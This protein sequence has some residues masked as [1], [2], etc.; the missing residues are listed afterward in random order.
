MEARGDGSLVSVECKC[1]AIRRSL[2]ILKH[3]GMEKLVKK[4]TFASYETN[5]PWQETAKQLAEKFAHDPAGGWFLACG[6][7]GSGKTHLCVAICREMMLR[8]RET[9]YMLWRDSVA[10]LKGALNSDDYD[11]I[12]KPLKTVPVL[13]IDDFYKV[14]KGEQPTPADVNIAFEL[15]NNRYNDPQLVTVISTE[16]SM[17]EM[18]SIDEATASRIYERSKGHVLS[19]MGSDKNYRLHGGGQHGQ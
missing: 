19:L 2:T 1:M 3:S 12:L 10:Q 5:H 9:R 18:L 13:Y 4:C 17:E 6:N 11:R 7:A 8:G 14:G 15:L 16:R